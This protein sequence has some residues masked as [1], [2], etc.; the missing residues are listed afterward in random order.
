MHI[1]ISISIYVASY[2]YGRIKRPLAPTCSCEPPCISCEPPGISFESRAYNKLVL[3][4][5]LI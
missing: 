3:M 5:S 2:L 4:A 1:Y